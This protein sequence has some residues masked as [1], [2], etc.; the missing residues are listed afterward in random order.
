MAHIQPGSYPEPKRQYDASVTRQHGRADATVMLLGDS[1]KKSTAPMRP[2]LKLC[3][4]RRSES[5]ETFIYEGKSGLVLINVRIAKKKEKLVPVKRNI[6]ELV[7]TT[8]RSIHRWDGR[9]NSRTS[10][11]WKNTSAILQVFVLTTENSH[12]K[13]KST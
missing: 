10:T 8:H 1:S 6:K 12:G 4:T 11:H 13:T 3:E 5:L 7:K 2:S 9:C